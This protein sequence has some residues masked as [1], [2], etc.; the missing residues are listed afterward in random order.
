M[1]FSFFIYNEIGN[2]INNFTFKSTNNVVRKH[3]CPRGTLYLEEIVRIG[4]NTGFA[5]RA[6]RFVDQDD[7][8]VFVRTAYGCL[9]SNK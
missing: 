4:S 8:S 5:D 6:Y 1:P 2:A 3:V 7:A 9:S